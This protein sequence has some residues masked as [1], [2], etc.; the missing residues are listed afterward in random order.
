MKPIPLSDYRDYFT[1]KD[2][3]RNVSNDL[4]FSIL[5]NYICQAGCK[6]CYARKFFPKKLDASLEHVDIS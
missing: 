2:G 3:I 1:F 6:H 5:Q 4:G